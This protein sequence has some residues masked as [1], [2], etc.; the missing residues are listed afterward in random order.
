MK[1]RKFVVA[2]AVFSALIVLCATGSDKYVKAA[3]SSDVS[4]VNIYRLYNPNSGEHFY[5][6]TKFERNSLVDSGWDY[7]GV[8]W[9]APETG[10]PVYRLYNPNSGDHYYT[11]SDFERDNLVAQGWNYEGIYWQS[12]GPVGVSVAY[13][14]NAL[15]GVHNFTTSQTEETNLLNNGWQDGK[16][17]WMAAAGGTRVSP[18]TSLNLVGDF[19]DPSVYYENGTYYM[20]GTF[21]RGYHIPMATSGD[22][23]NFSLSGEALQSMPSYSDGLASSAPFVTKIADKYIM[24]L[25]YWTGDRCVIGT[26]TASSPTG[27][28]VPA[29][30]PLLVPSDSSYDIY[31]ASIFSSNGNNF[32]IYSTQRSAG[33]ANWIVQLSSDGLSVAGTPVKLLD[34][35]EITDF[36][37]KQASS[38]V[39]SPALTQA[40]DGTYVMFYGAN[41]ADKD[42]GYTGYATS[43]SIAGPYTDHGAVLRT[44]NV[45][46]GGPDEM[47]LFMQ[48]GVQR[49]Y[50][51][52]WDGPHN[53]WLSSTG[54]GRSVYSIDFHWANGHTPIVE[55]NLD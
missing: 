54:H 24:Y 52:G 37:T 21:T 14:P 19:P 38:R 13:N 17:A 26:A 12:G 51:N 36:Y 34:S 46:V 49:M 1:K 18:T 43:S 4:D 35:A 8:G 30:Q 33:R 25:H 16:T 6:S 47:Q 29:S 42:T 20:Y 27:P 31:D 22:G 28:F 23:K 45:G 55:A 7:E 15:S 32:L 48:N 41:D 39:E 3:P 11:S 53:S 40:P 2:G 50:F 10:A 44:M 9:A 5:T